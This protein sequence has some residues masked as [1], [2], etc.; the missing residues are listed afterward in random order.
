MKN[1]R[2][3]RNVLLLR[4]S[5]P[6]T[7]YERKLDRWIFRILNELF[8]HS[9]ISLK[10]WHFLLL[11]SQHRSRRAHSSPRTCEDAVGATQSSRVNKTHHQWGRI[12]QSLRCMYW[13]IFIFVDKKTQGQWQGPFRVRFRS[14]WPRTGGSDPA[15]RAQLGGQAKSTLI[16]WL[17]SAIR[18]RIKVA[19]FGTARKNSLGTVRKIVYGS[20]FLDH[21]LCLT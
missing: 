21:L 6:K 14:D 19:K 8:R 2:K 16:G 5:S 13:I 7:W 9:I 15:N 4:M 3:S 1:Y 17:P 11:N 20:V 18:R 10:F 12:Q